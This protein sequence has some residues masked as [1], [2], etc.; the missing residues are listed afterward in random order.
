MFTSSSFEKKSFISIVR[1][2][3]MFSIILKRKNV[4]KLSEQRHAVKEAAVP[5]PLYTCLHVKKNEVAQNF[6]GK[7]IR[8]NIITVKENVLPKTI[9]SP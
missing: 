2:L 9:H 1:S 4:P 5:M 8:K 3:K 7:K 6:C